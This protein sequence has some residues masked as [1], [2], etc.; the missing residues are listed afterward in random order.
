MKKLIYGLIILFISGYL[1]FLS[2]PYFGI[3]VTLTELTGKS[4][5]FLGAKAPA[6]LKTR[7]LKKLEPYVTGLDTPR[8]MYITQNN[9][10][11]VAEPYLGK[12]VLI[13][14]NQPQNRKVI[15]SGL[16][17]PH[18]MDMHK[19]YLYIAEENAIGRIKFNPESR[20]TKGNYK[21]IIKNIPHNKGHWTRTIKFGKDGYG[22]VSI[23]SSCNVCIEKNKYRATI[24]RFK[25]GI[26][27][28]KVYATGLRNSVGFDWSP[29]D[30][31]L[32]ATDNGRD[33]LGDHFPP[34]ELNRI[35]QN[36]FYG[37][38]Y[39][40][41]DK[42]PDPKF[43]K[44]HQKQIEQS[45]SPVFQFGAHN[46]PLGITF[47]KNKNS[48]LYGKALV[49][50]HGSWN[51]SV[52]VGYKV[53]ILSFDNHQFKEQTFINGFLKNGRVLGRPVHLVE[54]KKNKIYL[55][56]DFNGTIYRFNN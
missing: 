23:G 7:E 13:P 16:K 20:T 24:S 40:N 6:Y 19:G 28:L 4:I 10:L 37:W 34:D 50:L 48:K 44:G 17:K 9:D 36:G 26:N 56:D 8:F 47:I 46:A 49:A 52:K 27:Q 14:N 15:L 2:L 53:V 21:R 42:V 38:P 11:M 25:P 39:A 54:G 29:L 55:S 1:L 30:G 45:I 5:P 31:K 33:W 22:Y 18:S 3:N 41:G 43:G 51:S 32:Y 12:I 35:R